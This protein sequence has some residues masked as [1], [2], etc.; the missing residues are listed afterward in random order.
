MKVETI[1]QRLDRGELVLICGVGRLLHHNLLQILG[2]RGGFH[3]VW[4][5]QEHVGLTVSQIEVGTLAARS[6]GMDSFVRIAPTDYALVTRCYEAG[7]SGIMAA[8][9]HSAKQAEEVVRWAKFAPR[10]ARGLNTG[11]WDAEF[12][13]MP[14]ETF[15]ET[16]NREH[17]VAIQIETAGSVE[18]CEA[19]AAIDGVDILFV[20]PADLS[21]NLGVTGQFLDERCL[22][23]LDRVAE[24]CRRHGKHW[25]AV[26]VSPEH[27]ELLVE[28][29]CRL[30]SPAADV[31]IV[32]SGIEAI[33]QEYAGL[34]ASA[35][36]K[37]T[38]AS[39]A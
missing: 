33:K 28:K 4:F 37:G 1:K 2:L 32:N 25:G 11:G 10:G 21:Q 20:G 12:A 35:S 6:L 24:A 18:E 9:I 23:A 22:A 27:A 38:A 5:D 8:Q 29:G 16:A 3:G 26:C 31:K 14:L 7:A 39:D 13:A 17:Y 36:G 19:I 34:F 30:I 15:C